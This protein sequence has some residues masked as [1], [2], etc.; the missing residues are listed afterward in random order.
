MIL[1]QDFPDLKLS[2][3]ENLSYYY[4]ILSE[5]GIKN[6]LK[7]PFDFQ[8]RHLEYYKS[9]KIRKEI[10]LDKELEW[11]FR[12]QFLLNSFRSDQSTIENSLSTPLISYLTH[13]KNGDHRSINWK[14]ILRLFC[15]SS[16]RTKIVNTIHRGSKRFGTFPGIRIKKQ[17]RILVA[18]DTSGSIKES[19][20][21]RFF[22]EIHQ[23]WKQRV[24]IRIVECDTI[25]H[26]EY[27]YK[28]IFPKVVTG[29]GNTDFNEPIRFSNEVFQPDALIYFTDG[30]GPSPRLKSLKPVLWVIN[31]VG[32]K[33]HS[34]T[35]NDLPGRK[36]KMNL[37]N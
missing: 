36:V 14:R 31:N 24:E 21:E 9:W 25:I 20:F 19:D 7:K 18:I 35:W 3:F 17:S 22:D 10:N 37:L 4:G 1:P 13:L 12:K 34:K 32:I 23:L 33:R 28:G 26:Q 11:H 2:P 16:L 27:N 15:N 8:S 30:F 29:R 5:K 6:T